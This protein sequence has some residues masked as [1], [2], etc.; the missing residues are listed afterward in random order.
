[1]KGTSLM[2]H[3]R[4]GH[5]VGGLT[6]QLHAAVADDLMKAGIDIH[7][8]IKTIDGDAIRLIAYD[9]D[10]RYP[11]VGEVIDTEAKVGWLARWSREGRYFGSPEAT[12]KHSMAAF[13]DA[14][15]DK[16]KGSTT[17]RFDGA[18]KNTANTVKSVDFDK[19]PVHDMGLEEEQKPA[20]VPIQ[21]VAQ[22]FDELANLRVQLNYY[23]NASPPVTA[24]TPLFV[25]QSKR[26]AA[27]HDAKPRRTRAFAKLFTYA[28]FG[29][30]RWYALGGQDIPLECAE[31]IVEVLDETDL[32]FVYLRSPEVA[33]RLG[34]KNPHKEFVAAVAF[35]AKHGGLAAIIESGN[36]SS[37]R[38]N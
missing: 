37:A 28:A 32:P 4:I 33:S 10:H 19:E 13:T 7:R 29:R 23:K 5:S 15:L 24:A 2:Y 11:L 21:T 18:A 8:P 20:F 30:F 26:A 12:K 31:Q 34:G 6:M 1:M 16:C 22:E 9:G 35:A 14:F 36:A 25:D 27:N 17:D 3:N 38:A